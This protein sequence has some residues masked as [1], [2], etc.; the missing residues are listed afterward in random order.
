MYLLFPV[1]RDKTC[2]KRYCN[3]IRACFFYNNRI[4]KDT[5]VQEHIELQL[6]LRLDL[7]GHYPTLQHNETE[8]FKTFRCVMK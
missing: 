4:D 1:D 5:L 6:V 3:C 7:S 2:I 8:I